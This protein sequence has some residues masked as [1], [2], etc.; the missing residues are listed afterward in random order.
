M[1]ICLSC[2]SVGVE[3]ESHDSSHPYYVRD[4]EIPLFVHNWSAGDETKL[5][6]ALLKYGIGNWEEIAKQFVGR[7]AAECEA[8]Y[9][10]YYVE[11]RPFPDLPPF[12]ESSLSYV[13][14]PTYRFRINRVDE[15]PRYP[16]D[17]VPHRLLAGYNPGRAEFDMEHENEAESVLSDVDLTITKPSDPDHQFVRELQAAL[18]ENYNE[19]LRER[20]RRHRVI[21]DHGL[22][23]MRKLFSWMHLY[24]P[25]LTR[26]VVERMMCFIQLLTSY[27]LDVLFET[28]SNVVLLQ[29]EF[30]Q[31]SEYRSM[32]ITRMETIKLYTRLKAQREE[33]QSH[34]TRYLSIPLKNSPCDTVAAPKLHLPRRSAPPLDIIG[35]PGYQYLSPSERELCSTIRI[36]PECY[37]EYKRVLQMESKKNGYLKLAQARS[38]IKIDVNKTRKLFDFLVREGYIENSLQVTKNQ[39][40]H[41]S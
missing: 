2:F 9:I 6:D 31:L 1:N 27:E 26:P 21:K 35:L 24:E 13:K 36:M 33:L 41:D 23:I 4:T 38:M 10:Q 28:M 25:T 37:T 12:P 22:I 18:A 15:P 29:Q 39:S 8:H 17:S 11:N 7:S 40:L 16:L 14:T 30:N 19:T 20:E 3:T 5:L 34:R 32:G